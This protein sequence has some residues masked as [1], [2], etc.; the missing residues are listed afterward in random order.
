VQLHRAGGCLGARPKQEWDC[1]EGLT[2]DDGSSLDIGSLRVRYSTGGLKPA[3]LIEELWPRLAEPAGSGS[4]VEKEQILAYARALDGKDPKDLT[5]YGT[6][7]AIKDNIDLAGVPTTAACAAFA[8][9]P[10]RSG[11]VVQRLIDAG[12]ISLGKTNV[13]GRSAR[14]LESAAGRLWRGLAQGMWPA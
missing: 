5:L 3:A 6:P 8:Y 2:G 12:A 13:A 7:F 1:Q 10:Q 9:T 11:T 4:G 14:W